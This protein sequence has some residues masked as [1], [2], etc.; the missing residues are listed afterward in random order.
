MIEGFN[1]YFQDVLDVAHFLQVLFFSVSVC[2]VLSQ[3]PFET[4][5]WIKG[6]QCIGVLAATIAIESFL[7]ALALSM[8]TKP[9]FSFPTTYMIVV[10]VYSILFSKMPVR[11]TIINSITL[12]TCTVL[13]TE[14]IKCFAWITSVESK[15][16]QGLFVILW[17]LLQLATMF[18]LYKFSLKKFNYIS[19]AAT[20]T[21]LV[22]NCITLVAIVVYELLMNKVYAGELLKISMHYCAF[23][24]LFLFLVNLTI[25][26]TVYFLCRS[27]A[28]ILELQAENKMAKADADYMRLTQKKLADM[29]RVK[30]DIGN[31]I[32]YMSALLSKGQYDELKKYF[33]K[34]NR[35]VDEAM[36]TVQCGNRAV[37]I[38]LNMEKSKAEAQGVQIQFDICIPPRLP[39]SDMHMCS[40]LSNLLDNA[41]EAKQQFPAEKD[42]YVVTVRMST[43]R[44]FLY[45]AVLNPVPENGKHEELA[46]LESTK[47]SADHGFGTK[48][49]ERIAKNYNGYVNYAVE[50][51]TFIA[52]VMLDILLEEK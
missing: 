18:V 11:T 30:H 39:F 47:Q 16:I 26:L 52:E 25:H 9:S 31:H 34:F 36:S 21:I 3:D 7:F 20:A 13:I 49:V 17:N 37:N 15:E 51:D 45:I 40:L 43:R 50:N 14:L 1:V 48:I 5:W 10:V 46:L 19:K 8:Q 24:G 6:L 38:I 44:E 32:S 42:D 28:K 22:S 23:S 35:E 27:N 4:R 33:E 2:F 12:F 29:R 41:I